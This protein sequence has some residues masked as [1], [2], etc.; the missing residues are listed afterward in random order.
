MSMDPGQTPHGR[1]AA[2]FAL[3]L[4][5]G[6]FDQAHG[7]LT[8]TA[9]RRWELATL[10]TTF[11]EMVEYFETPPNHVEV[12]ETMTEWPAREP[13]DVGWAYAAISSESESEAVTV[14]VSSEGGRHLIRSIEWYR[15]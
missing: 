13:S 6:D 5:A 12:M 2:T 8:S 15:P 14:V 9:K 10:R 4:V 11:L 7:M 3:A 1:V